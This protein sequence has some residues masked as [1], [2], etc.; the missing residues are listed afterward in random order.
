MS[1][2][3]LEGSYGMKRCIGYAH[4]R[5]LV[6]ACH[7]SGLVNMSATTWSVGRHRSLIVPCSTWSF[8]KCHFRPMCLVFSLTKALWEYAIALW[9]TS[10]M[11]DVP[12]WGSLKISPVSWRRW[13]PPR[14]RPPQ[15]NT[16]PRRLTGPRMFVACT[17]G[18]HGRDYV[19]KGSHNGTCA[20]CY[21][22]PNLHSQSL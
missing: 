11:V 15:N 8:K 2:T 6:S 1:D 19:G 17:C 14:W 21:C 22:W 10:Q 9:L 7:G 20:C 12:V 5:C 3:L 16:L 4:L 13:R 18:W